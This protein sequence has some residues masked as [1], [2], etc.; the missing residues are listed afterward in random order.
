MP[1]RNRYS[2]LSWGK[3]PTGGLR[4]QQFHTAFVK[5]TEIAGKAIEDRPLRILGPTFSGSLDSLNTELKRISD[6]RPDWKIYVYSGS[7][8]DAVSI[9]RFSRGP[10]T[11]HF[12]SFQEN[13]EYT[14][15]RFI[16]FICSKDYPPNEIATLSEDET[17][18]GALSQSRPADSSEQTS[19]D[20]LH[21]THAEQLETCREDYATEGHKHKD[22]IQLHFPREI[23]YFRSAY[24][25][26]IAAQQRPEAKSIG[27][28]TLHLDLRE[29]G[30][31]DD[32]VSLYATAQT[33]LSQEAVMRGVLTELQ[34]HHVK[35]TILYASDPADQL[36]LARYLRT[37][38][39]QGRVV[40]TDPDLLF[41]REEDALLRGVL[42]ISSYALV[43]GLS[44]ELNPWGH[45]EETHRD[46]LFVSGISVGT[47]NAMLG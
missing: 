15:D 24:Q 19:P 11:L 21:E 6:Q 9:K 13:D 5:M 37:G 28:S 46:Q 26:E 16:Q 7:V 8:T 4:K 34:K 47:Y 22:V 20:H 12:S 43:P 3:A 23:S 38:F 25:K 36:F 17:V 42:G 33:P 35:F 30:R 2:C 40:I 31:D 44:D 32:A 1:T 18:F 45:P 27:P 10:G 14:R 39:P 29:E 41:S